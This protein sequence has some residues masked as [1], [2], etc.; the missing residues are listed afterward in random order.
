LDGFGHGVATNFAGCAA[1]ATLFSTTA[2]A[3]P[4]FRVARQPA[5]RKRGTM[6]SAYELAMER[7]EKQAPTTRLTEEQ[8][9]ELSE[10][11]ALFKARIAERELGLGD[12]I[13]QARAQQRAEDAAKLEEELAT[14]LRRL[15]EECEAR[16]ARV[17]AATP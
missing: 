14:D 5:T 15:R 12:R 10:I 3:R 7:L 9:R 2:T 16:K 1:A 13:A 6:K 8:K 17:R 11:E 4:R